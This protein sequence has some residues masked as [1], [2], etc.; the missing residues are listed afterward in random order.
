PGS[1]TSPSDSPLTVTDAWIVRSV[2][3]P[4]SW[5]SLPDRRA[6]IPDSTGMAPPRVETARPAVP[7][8]STRT[9][10]SHRNFTA[11][12]FLV[13]GSVATVIGPVNFGWPPVRA[14]QAGHD[15]PAL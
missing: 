9:S 15:Y 5:S 6:R 14:G 8:A 13:L 12:R 10:R 1:T 2:S 7:S 4:V 11:A 3:L